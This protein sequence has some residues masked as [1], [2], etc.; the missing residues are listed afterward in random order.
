MG[1]CVRCG[2]CDLPGLL[3]IRDRFGI[4]CLLVSGGRQALAA[5]KSSNVGGV[6][7][8]ACE[9]ELI[10]GIR[11]AFPKPVMAIP[12]LRPEGPCRNTRVDIENLERT[13]CDLIGGIQSGASYLSD[14]TLDEQPAIKPL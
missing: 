1:E 2:A 7:A 9:P 11:A 12:N 14:R 8:V 13:L 6:I 5:V 4:R 10:A 3:K